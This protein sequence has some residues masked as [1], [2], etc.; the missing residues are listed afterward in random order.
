MAATPPASPAFRTRGQP[1]A[2]AAV[3]AML[4]GGM[5]HALLLAGPAGVGKST[6]AEDIAAG[7]LC[8]TEDRGSRP[9]RECRACRA[10]QHG[11]HPDLHRLVPTGAGLVIPIGGREERGVRDLVRDLSLHPVEGG[12]RVAIVTAA[13]RMTED[14]QSAFLKT[15]EEPPA[16]TVLILT[17]ADEERLLP[18]IRSRCVRLRLGPVPRPDV[19]QI[20]V[21]AGLV[22]A[23]LAAR[24]ARLSAG[25][26]GDA[27]ALARA[28]E[29]LAIRGEI[30]RTLLDLAAAH[31]ADRLRIGRDLLARAAELSAGIRRAAE[32]SEPG[33]PVQRRPPRGRKGGAERAPST[34]EPAAEADGAVPAARVPAAERR[35][36]ALTLVVIW[37]DVARDLALVGLG[38][39]VVVRQADLLDDLEAAAQRLSVPF[40]AAQLH[41]LDVAGERLEGNVSPELVIDA[42]AV[43]WATAAKA[44]ARG[45]GARARADARVRPARAGAA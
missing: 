43:G 20:L 44:R 21:E 28:P 3:T 30:A 33:P 1:A 29:S 15:L 40:A 7:L 11:N 35:A 32:S 5:P 18:T 36:A 25:R 42:L 6:L 4:G 24:L 26:P 37:R 14:A 38:E 39:H 34:V 22:D 13:D 8:R 45:D 27:V 12:M 9:C 23:P 17:A 2:V 41:R 31:R 16:R 10:L 19:E